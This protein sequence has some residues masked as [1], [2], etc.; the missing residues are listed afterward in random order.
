ML[1]NAQ[2]YHLSLRSLFLFCLFLSGRFTLHRFFLLYLIDCHINPLY[3]DGFSHTDKSNKDKNVH[4]IIYGATYWNYG[5]YLSLNIVLNLANSA[6]PG[7]MQH[8][9]AFH[10][11][12][13][14]L[15]KDLFGGF[16]YTKESMI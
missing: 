16:Q 6:D 3:S 4:C 9:A 12:I 5:A 7:E 1:Q 15:P 10:L 8:C 13:H 2:S 11:C 14:C